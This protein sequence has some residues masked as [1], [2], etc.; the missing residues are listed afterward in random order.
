MRNVGEAHHCGDVT[1]EVVLKLPLGLTSVIFS[2]GESWKEN[3]DDS[4]KS[5]HLTSATLAH[6]ANMRNLQAHWN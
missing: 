4:Y 1:A 5:H 3:H 2:Q 6:V